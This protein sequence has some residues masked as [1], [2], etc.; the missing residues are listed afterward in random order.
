MNYIK[1]FESYSDIWDYTDEIFSFLRKYN[2]F[3]EQERNLRTAYADQIEEW[4]NQ[5]RNTRDFANKIVS[6]LQLSDSGLMQYNLSGGGQWQNIY[7]M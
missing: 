5:G 6:D 3:P 4:Y 1:T 2:L 7:Y